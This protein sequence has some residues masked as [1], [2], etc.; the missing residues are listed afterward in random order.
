MKSFLKM[1]MSE[2]KNA[3]CIVLVL[4]YDDITYVPMCNVSYYSFN[5]E[6]MIKV[7]YYCS[8]V[9]CLYYYGLCATK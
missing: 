8:I 5:L 1:Y 2:K 4:C 9:Y 3:A 6:I 7:I